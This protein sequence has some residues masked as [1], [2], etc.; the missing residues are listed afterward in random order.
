MYG[1]LPKSALRKLQR[2]AADGPEMYI[3]AS[4]TNNSKKQ[5]LMKCIKE[6]LE[7]SSSLEGLSTL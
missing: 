3:V 4:S 2:V 7:K 5:D 1:N 6:G